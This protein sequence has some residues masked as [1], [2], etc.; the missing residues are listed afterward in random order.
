MMCNDIPGAITIST[1]IE[2]A[3][4]FSHIKIFFK[5]QQLIVKRDGAK[6]NGLDTNLERLVFW[7]EVL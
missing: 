3:N 4:T 6:C 5:L 7:F 1:L 2:F